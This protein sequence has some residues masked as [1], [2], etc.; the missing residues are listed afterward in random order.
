MKCSEC[1]FENIDKAKFCNQCGTRM[2]VQCLDCK[3]RNPVGSKFCFECG[4]SLAAPAPSK[5]PDLSFEEKISKMQ[6]YLPEGLTEKI[7][8]QR[9]RIEGEKKQVTVLFCDM[10]GFTSL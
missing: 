2:E 10:E 4:R 3:T 8:S 5:S 1:G 7:L 6:K 9:N